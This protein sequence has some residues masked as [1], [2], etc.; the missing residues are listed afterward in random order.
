MTMKKLFTFLFLCS[1]VVLAQGTNSKIHHN[2]ELVL[3]NTPSNEFVNV[4]AVLSEQFPVNELNQQTYFLTRKEKQSEVVRLLKEFALPRQQNVMNFLE[5][6]KSQNK[7]NNIRSLWALN[8]IVFSATPDVIYYL[9]T[10]HN[11][12]AHHI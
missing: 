7:V 11:H 10:F 5:Q 9:L 12:T 1:F 6:E 2:L 4:Y 8:T 3:L